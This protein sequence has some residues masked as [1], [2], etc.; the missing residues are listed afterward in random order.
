MN[1]LDVKYWWADN[2]RRNPKHLQKFM[3]HWHL[4]L[5]HISYELAWDGTVT[6]WVWAMD[7]IKMIFR[8]IIQN[9]SE[10]GLWNW[11]RVLCF[12]I[13]LTIIMNIW[14]D[15]YP[16]QTLQDGVS[17]GL[18]LLRR[19]GESVIAVY[20]TVK[21]CQCVLFLVHTIY[22]S[23]ILILFFSTLYFYENFFFFPPPPPPTLRCIF[24]TLCPC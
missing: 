3:S 22:P 13:I 17:Y 7:N 2:K 6:P 10:M 4:C 24:F 14:H 15:D 11:A 9:E 16:H 18:S 1:G 23:S 12:A 8:E 21:R 5:P 19:F 20:V